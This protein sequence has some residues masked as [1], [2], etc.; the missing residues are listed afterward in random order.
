MQAAV[1]GG[2][3]SLACPPDTDPPLDEPGLVEML[4]HRARSLNQAHVYPLGALTVGLEGHDADRDGRARRGRLRRVLAGRR[5]AAPTRRCCCARC[6]TRRPSATAC[7]CARRTR[8]SRAAAWRTTARSRRGS[9]CRPFPP[10]RRRIALATILELVRGTG[11]RVHLCRLSTRRGRGDGARR[12]ARRAA[13]DLRRRHPS[14]ASV[15]R[16]HR[17]VRRAM[18]PD[19]AAARH[20]RPRRA[21]RGR[22]PTARSTSSAPITRRSTT[23]ASRCR[24][25]R[26]SRAPRASSCCCRSRS[27]GRR[28]TALRCRGA[29]AHHVA[30]RRPSSAATPG[31]LGV[32]RPPTS[33]SSIPSA[34]AR[35]ARPPLKSQGKNTPFL[36]LE[37]RGRCAHASSADRSSTKHE[38]RR[39]APRRELGP[40]EGQRSG[41]SPKR[42]G[43]SMSA[44]G[45]RPERGNIVPVRH[46][47]TAD[48]RAARARATTA[49]CCGS[50]G[51]RVRGK[52]TTRDGARAPPVRPPLAGLY[53]RWRQH[54]S[55]C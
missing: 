25:A 21:A 28:R 54:S 26:P 19:A 10:S 42:G 6:S 9:A 36:G 51:F 35:R 40:L 5:A 50:P 49:P 7:G 23:T 4:K 12:K 18:P 48:E 53:A 52:S 27:N 55:R 30:A 20:A 15:R 47:V 38:R 44:A 14:S 32:G 17:L 3:T 45:E 37:V 8:I 33:A 31:T 41:V 46:Q 43:T 2:V 16:R 1:A 24:S 11:A 34:M 39:A 22:W 29:R 13:G